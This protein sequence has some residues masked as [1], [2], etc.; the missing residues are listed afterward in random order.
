MKY[1][2]KILQVL[3][4]LFFLLILAV[5]PLHS[6]GITPGRFKDVFGFFEIVLLFTFAFLLVEWRKNTKL[7]RTWFGWGWIW[8]LIILSVIGIGMF[9]SAHARMERIDTESANT[10][11]GPWVAY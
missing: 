8:T 1:A 6:Y 3:S 9:V 4:I 7:K 11:G 10:S 2:K 5:A